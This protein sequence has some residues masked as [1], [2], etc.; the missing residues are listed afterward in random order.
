LNRA[1]E[2]IDAEIFVQACNPE[3]KFVFVH[4]DT[5][6]NF[7]AGAEEI[8][9]E[10]ASTD[11]DGVIV[12]LPGSGDLGDAAI[13]L[14]YQYVSALGGFA[15]MK[16]VGRQILDLERLVRWDLQRLNSLHHA[17]AEAGQKSWRER[18]AALWQFRGWRRK[19]RFY[20]ARLWLGLGSLE[21]SRRRWEDAH[22]SFTQTA[23]EAGVESLFET[24]TADEAASVSGLD[25]AFIEASVEH[26]GSRLDNSA[27]VL[28][29]VLGGSAG[30][31]VAA[32]IT[33]L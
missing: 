17:R 30:A 2:R 12:T 13:M 27:V 11:N 15:R 7:D 20:L 14:W 16:N 21:R 6:V 18:A 4:T 29:T 1:A 23:S 33:Q 31:V 9:I 25:L 3:C 26:A 32:I 10:A 5:I 24:D 8:A 28:A 19:S 22:F